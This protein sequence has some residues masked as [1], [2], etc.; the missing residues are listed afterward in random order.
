MLHGQPLLSYDYKCITAHSSQFLWLFSK[1]RKGAEE[2][3]K[4]EPLKPP[5]HVFHESS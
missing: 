3:E 2:T 5:E 4:A 1:E